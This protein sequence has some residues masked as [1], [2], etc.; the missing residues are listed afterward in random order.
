MWLNIIQQKLKI[1]LSEI[2]QLS[3]LYMYVLQKTFEE[4]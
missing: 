2:S 1:Y 4:E 3:K